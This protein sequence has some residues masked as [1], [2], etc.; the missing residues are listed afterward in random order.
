MDV[1]EFCAEHGEVLN[2]SACR[3]SLCFSGIM[4]STEYII[5]QSKGL[6]HCPN[7]YS[8]RFILQ[9]MTSINENNFPM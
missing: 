5:K 8:V 3:V 4:E 7:R 6:R 2:L 9:T 1:N